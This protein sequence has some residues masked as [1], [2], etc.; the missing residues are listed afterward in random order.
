MGLALAAGACGKVS[1]LKARKSF[2]EANVLYQRQD[3]QK[4]AE[5]YEEV[6]QADPNLTTAYF[7]LGNSYDNLFK[8]SRR[9]EADNDVNL[10]KAIDN[11]KQSVDK[12]SNPQ[13]KKLALQFLVAAYGPDKANDP[14]QAE[15]IVQKMIDLEPSDPANYFVLAKIYE[16]AGNYEQAEAILLK[17]KEARPNDSSVYMQLAGYYNR[18]GE[19]DKTIEALQQRAAKEPNNPEAHYTIATYYWDKAYRDFRL[20]DPEKKEMVQSGIGAVDRALEIKSDYLDAVVYK[21]L[22]LRLQANLEKDVSKQQALLKEAE[23]LSARA[24]D[25]Q[26]KKTAGVGD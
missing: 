4:A 5:K 13:M 21:G 14:S 23:A 7:Y 24:K 19:F 8:T 20:K 25:L 6:L 22:L 3:Y 2:K 15:P 26:K 17:A 18:Q 1:N 10:T 9:G 16:D 11:Y 12:E